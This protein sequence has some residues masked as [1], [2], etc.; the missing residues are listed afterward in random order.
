M[1]IERLSKRQSGR[2]VKR[3]LEATRAER[4]EAQRAVVAVY[5]RLLRNDRFPRRIDKLLKRVRSRGVEKA[6]PEIDSFGVWART[7]LRPMVERFFAAVPD[8]QTDEAV[9]HQFRIRGKQLRYAMELLLGAF[10][11]EFRTRLYPAIE[12]LLDQLGEINDLATAK[13]RLLRKCE[14]AGDAKGGAQVALLLADEQARFDE[15]R[16]QFWEWCSPE[17]LRDL[18]DGFDKVLGDPIRRE[19][20]TD[21]LSPSPLAGPRARQRRRR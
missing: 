19:N 8:D 16:R 10:S 9:L 17:R 15:T 11:E 3:W 6:A 5:Q 18:R 13:T 12:A 4:A 7:Q 14:E 21:R 2:G 1:L 20:P